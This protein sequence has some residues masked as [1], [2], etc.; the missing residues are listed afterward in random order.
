MPISGINMNCPFIL[1]L[2]VCGVTAPPSDISLYIND[3]V[4]TL[5]SL[6][7]EIRTLDKDK[8]KLLQSNDTFKDSSDNDID[9]DSKLGT[10][11]KDESD[12]GEYGSK[13]NKEFE[14]EANERKMDI[15]ECNISISS[16][17]IKYFKG[18]LL[19]HQPHF[20][21]FRLHF[22]ENTEVQYTEEVFQGKRWFWTYNTSAGPLPFISWNLDYALLSFGLLDAKTIHIPSVALH[23]NGSCNLTL[24]SYNTSLL[25][26]KALRSLVKPTK[27]A[28]NNEFLKYRE[29]YFCYLFADH[30]L[31]GTIR[32]SAAQYMMYPCSYILYK[33]CTVSYNYSSDDYVNLCHDRQIPGVHSWSQTSHLPAVLVL[34]I[35]AFFP[36][37]VFHYFAWISKRDLAIGSDYV[38]DNH[39]SVEGFQL[40]EE[41]VNWIYADGKRSPLTF[42]D[43]FSFEMFGM[44]DK[45][46]ILT[47]RLRRFIL[48]LLAPVVIMIK[49]AWY[50]EGLGMWSD[51]DKITMEDLIKVGTPLGFHAILVDPW[52]KYKTFVPGLGGALSISILYYIL[53]FLFM[54]LPRCVKQVVE[55]G[56]PSSNLYIHSPLFFGFKEIL[57]MSKLRVEPE[58]LETGYLKGAS[59]MKCS[60]YLLFTTK[61]WVRVWRIQSRRIP[62]MRGKRSPCLGALWILIFPLYITFCIL[63]I[64]TCL[65]YYGLPICFIVVVMVK[66]AIKSLRYLRDQNR[67]LSD[68]CNYKIFIALGVLTV[69][70]MFSILAYIVSLVAFFSLWLIMHVIAMCFIAVII[71][72][73]VSFGYLFFI[74]IVLYYF[75][76]Q[77]RNFS[78]V[79]SDLLTTAVE[80]SKNMAEEPY[81]VAFIDDYISITNVS[82]ETLKGIK[83][84]GTDLDNN[85]LEMFL[86]QDLKK[87]FKI[88]KKNHMFGIPKDLFDF[89]VQKHCPVHKQFL[90]LLFRVSVMIAFVYVT[91]GISSNYVSGPTTE[92]SEVMHVIFIVVVGVIPQLIGIAFANSNSALVREIEERKIEESIEE[93]WSKCDK[94]VSK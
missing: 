45:Y 55:D 18:Q 49:L 1:L 60:F 66:G 26:T 43:L 30:E 64:A 87:R 23:V 76:K 25:L 33:C 40:V 51:N 67:V 93:Y 11:V 73:S 39:N 3:T 21:Q 42:Y 57:K 50:S 15:S 70:V 74:V 4:E 91:L 53:G 78:D 82:F 72:P 48:L 8:L 9:A 59:L 83:V 38:Q 77:I 5:K 71:Y 37:P 2:V 12:E 17:S 75:I 24:G 63:E 52:N 34:L 13:Q 54:V 36:I 35:I 86:D 94:L 6:I 7:S 88:R 85:S 80:I 68:I 56:L 19:Q 89:L 47:S 10:I 16:K 41:D 44:Y 14:L 69:F 92:I 84:N 46:P 31:L 62:C 22:L 81:R 79:Y 65:F 90:T 29:S 27:E 32:Y 20:V 61:F 58:Q 28:E